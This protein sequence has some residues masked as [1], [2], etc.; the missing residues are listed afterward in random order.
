MIK[1]TKPRISSKDETT[2]FAKAV[3]SGK[4]IAGN[5]VINA[6]AR[7]LKDLESCEIRELIFDVKA[8]QRILAFCRDALKLAGGEHEGNAFN[9]LPWQCFI[10]GS[11]FGWKRI[12]GTR[13]FRRAYVETG[14]GS[15]KSPLAAA[16]GLYGLT[17]DQ[18]P[19]A[20][21]YSAAANFDQAKILFKDA[22]AMVQQN[23]FMNKLIDIS[24]GEHR[25]NIGYAKQGSFFRPISSDTKKSGFRPNI[26]LID[27]LHEHPNRDTISMLERGFKGRV[28]P[29]LFMI[30]N[31]GYDRKS[32]CY[33]EHEYAVKVAS[34][35]IE[36]DT[37]FS[38]ICSLDEGDDP[39]TNEKC[40]IKANPSLGF[41]IKHDYLRQAV[42]QAKAI[43][44]SKSGILRLNFCVW[45][46]SHTSWMDRKTWEACEDATL[47]IEDYRDEDC[48]IGLDLGQTRDLTA[49]A[50]AFK[51]GLTDDNQQKYVVFAHG[52][53]PS[54]GLLD[55]AKQ[56]R[57]P[58]DVWVDKGHLTATKGRVTRLDVV[59][60]DLYRDYNRFNLKSVAYDTW[61]SGHFR[62]ELVHF[63][64]EFPLIQHS[65]GFNRVRD[66]NLTMPHSINT[67]EKLLLQKRLRVAVNPALRSAVMAAQFDSSP[68][69]LRRFV[70]QKATGRID[71]AIALTMAIGAA[72]QAEPESS[73]SYL[74]NNDLVVLGY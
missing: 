4:I 17:Q 57:A 21:I 42:A 39:L 29:L 43:E 12:D 45:T 14:K 32:V 40:W 73:A 8:A 46:D 68:S 24:G 48:W 11:L 5:N 36:N 25:P 16:I 6:C 38:F 3:T 69:G 34:G 61:M 71:M 70:K 35:A 20:E 13:R 1:P 59:A 72:T 10:L 64:A 51:D 58:Y 66:S 50:Y 74:E 19:R 27:E 30:T 63:D 22:V 65:Q 44:G 2:A 23:P 60:N 31:S 26:A 41:T 49:K 28:Q 53:L 33:E 54:D 62:D 55:R 18:E 15:G 56:D 67:F 47:N 9:P 52:Y 37:A 7:H